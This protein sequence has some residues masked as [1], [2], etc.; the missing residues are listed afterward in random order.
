MDEKKIGINAGKVWHALHDNRYLTKYQLVS[1]TDLSSNEIDAAIGWL[2]CENKIKREGEFFLLDNT[3]MK[4]TISLNAEILF[5]VLKEFPYS[6]NK[7]HEITEM[8]EVEIHQAI[9]WLSREKKINLTQEPV[10]SEIM[11]ETEQKIKVLQDEVEYLNQDLENRNNLIGHLSKQISDRQTEF[12]LQIGII[13][14]MHEQMNQKNDVLSKK[15]AELLDKDNEV[16]MLKTEISD[17]Y[18]DLDTR[19]QIIESLTK[20]LTEKQMQFMQKANAFEELQKQVIHNQTHVSPSLVGSD[21]QE[22]I[23]HVST[24][25]SMIEQTNADEKIHFESCLHNK[26]PV[27]LEI[28]ENQEIVETVVQPRSIDEIHNNVDHAIHE[29]IKTSKSLHG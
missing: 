19:N 18:T 11:D 2:A 17:L 21:L 4:E 29:K 16:T 20:Q 6:I 8:N 13:D 3:N 10:V 15:H 9:G 14:Q 22:R 25:Q 23:S 1:K 28:H 5:D 7:L 24:L 12:I 26:T 27:A